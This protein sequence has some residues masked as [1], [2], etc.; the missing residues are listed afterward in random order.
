MKLDELF[1]AA[2]GGPASAAVARHLREGNY[3]AAGRLLEQHGRLDDAVEAFMEGGELR[4][5]AA[6]LERLGKTAEAAELYTKAG[7]HRKGGEALARARQ[8]EQAAAQLLRKGNTLE[9]ARLFGVAGAWDQAADLYAKGGY[10]LRAA[11]AYEK[12]G[13]LAKAAGCYEQHFVENV[14]YGNGSTPASSSDQKTA[15]R[16]GQLYEE[17]ADLEKAL[18]IYGKGGYF[19]EAAKVA[20]ALGR[21][22]EA[23]ELFIRCEDLESAAVVLERAGKIVRAAQLRGEVAF[24]EDRMAEAAA[25]FLEG[26]DHYRAAELFESIGMLPE[27]AEAYESGGAYAE[28]GS[29]YV[30]AEQ[31]ERAAASYELGGQFETA[32]T[33]FEEIGDGAKAALLFEKAGLPFKSGVAAARAG[34]NERA[35]ALL[36]RVEPGDESFNEATEMLA[37]LFL[38][39]D[40]PQLALER[41]QQAVEDQPLSSSNVNVYYW[42]GVCREAL[43]DAAGA[44]EVYQKVLAVDFGFRDVTA[45]VQRLQA[46]ASSANADSLPEEAAPGSSPPASTPAAAPPAETTLPS[47]A[48]PRFRLQEEIGRGPLGTICRAVDQTDGRSVALRILPTDALNPDLL[49][50]VVS[51]LVA[52]AR[53]SH[54]NLVK[55]LGVVDFDGQNCVVSEY[56]KVGNLGRVLE[57]G[58]RMSVHQCHRLGRGLSRFLSFL[59]AR[60]IVHGSVQPSNIMEISGV[61]KVA[62]LGLGRLVRAVKAPDCYRAPEDRLD[63]AGDVYALGAVLYHLL[64]GVEPKVRTERASVNRPSQLAPGVPQRFDS[65]LLRCL[66]PR[67]EARFLGFDEVLESLE[68]MITI[69]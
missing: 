6:V 1:R 58:Q 3:L 10:P 42:L 28:A 57:A 26:Q 62:D 31:K 11:Q 44:L 50:P 41:L 45:R 24:K 20:T 52:A 29:V 17:V 9:A 4:A 21:L 61:I 14:A 30:R 16:A 43:D 56:V 25:H 69:S 63:L 66:D 13:D 15:L 38:E 33:L 47:A 8:P 32:A 22:E 19:K 55:V 7:D 23:G 40:M 65:F 36:Q 64:T 48:G 54:P 67:P 12:T 2:K 5:A 18:E 39:V 37:K 51:D 68:A 60:G 27:A 59:H 34:E 53:L 35:I 46:G 49:G